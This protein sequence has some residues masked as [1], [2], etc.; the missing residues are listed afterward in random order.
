MNLS[1]YDRWKLASREEYIMCKH[2]DKSISDCKCD[3]CIK[4]NENEFD[5]ECN[6]S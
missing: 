5:C 3:Y 1:K 4:C 6:G 2:C